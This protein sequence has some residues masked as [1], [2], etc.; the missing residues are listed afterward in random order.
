[1]KEASRAKAA[2]T[3]NHEAEKKM[4]MLSAVPDMCRIIKKYTNIMLSSVLS[5]SSLA[6][7]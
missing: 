2:M 4:I 1:M 7:F 6:C 3:R 5:C